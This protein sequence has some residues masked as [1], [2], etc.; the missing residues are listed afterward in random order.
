MHVPKVVFLLIITA[1]YCDDN[2]SAPEEYD[3][4]EIL[5]E[6][7]TDENEKSDDDSLGNGS[8]QWNYEDLKNHKYDKVLTFG[9]NFI[10]MKRK[11]ENGGDDE[12]INERIK[13]IKSL[14]TNSSW[15]DIRFENN[16][17]A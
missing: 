4:I 10:V 15:R 8:E 5:D 12:H 7:D 17:N 16:R 2:S 6:E 1:I 14:F 9:D 3:I 11:N 13:I